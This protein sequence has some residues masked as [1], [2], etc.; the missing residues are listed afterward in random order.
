MV[1]GLGSRPKTYEMPHGQYWTVEDLKSAA[2]IEGLE[3]H[4]KNFDVAV[5]FGA[6]KPRDYTLH[7]KNGFYGWE[8]ELI[9][10]S[11]EN[12]DPII[13]ALISL[14]GG[15]PASKEAPNNAR[16]SYV[17]PQSKISLSELSGFVGAYGN[18]GLKNPKIT[19]FR[20]EKVPNSVYKDA[21]AAG[22]K[23]QEVVESEK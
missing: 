22:L 1:F 10:Q 13:N 2:R 6:D 16:V 9:H 5:T 20:A 12:V 18:K 7:H 8:I 3:T 17:S 23:L 19:A 15:R 21:K 11:G 14:I 4:L